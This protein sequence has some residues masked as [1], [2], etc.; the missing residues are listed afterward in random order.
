MRLRRVHLVDDCEKLVIVAAQGKFMRYY[1]LAYSRTIFFFARSRT[2]S[3][4]VS[5][6]TNL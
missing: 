3:S 5:L 1:S 2:S 6:L 4:M